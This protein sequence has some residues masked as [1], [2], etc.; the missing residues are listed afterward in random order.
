MA[1]ERSYEYRPLVFRLINRF[2]GRCWSNVPSSFHLEK[3]R[4]RWSWRGRNNHWVNASTMANTRTFPAASSLSPSFP[5]GMVV[6]SDGSRPC[7]NSLDSSKSSMGSACIPVQIANVS[8]RDRVVLMNFPASPLV[9]PHQAAQI[10]GNEVDT[11]WLPPSEVG[12]V[13]EDFWIRNGTARRRSRKK[14]LRPFLGV[15][16]AESFAGY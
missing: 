12:T 7:R 10:D 14:G 8:Y 4:K 16:S 11:N 6:S 13:G 1:A 5:K 15:K 3:V 9:K 2:T